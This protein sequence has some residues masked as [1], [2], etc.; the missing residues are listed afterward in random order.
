MELG[1]NLHQPT[2]GAMPVNRGW[3]C[4]MGLVVEADTI[5][6]STVSANVRITRLAG[7]DQE[8]WLSSV[9]GIVDGRSRLEQGGSSRKE[10]WE[11]RTAA[12]RLMRLA[13]HFA[14]SRL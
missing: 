14:G 5:S 10:R 9:R 2:G 13:G 11:H 8:R 3:V 7:G 12:L 4:S 6:G 1:S